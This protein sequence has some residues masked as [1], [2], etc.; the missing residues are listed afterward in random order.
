MVLGFVASLM[1]QT[2]SPPATD[3]MDISL[4]SG[5]HFI[6]QDV[7]AAS[8]KAFDDSG[9]SQVAA[10]HEWNNLDGQDGGGYYQGP[11]WY[12]RHY[13]LGNELSGQRLFLKFDGAN[14]ITD[15]WINGSYVGQHHGGFA[16][17]AF[18]VTTYLTTGAD[19]VIAVRVDNTYNANVPP[20]Q[21]DFTFHGGMYRKVHLL[22]LD[23]VHI[24]PLDLASPGIFLKTTGVSSNAA[25]LQIT[26]LV[27]NAT[28]IIKNLTI[29][30]LVTDAGTNIVVA[31]TNLVTLAPGALS[32]V[33]SSTTVIS[34]HL[35]NGLLD[36]YLHRVYVEVWEAGTLLDLVSQ[37]L[38]FRYFSFDSTNGFS[39][40]G[41]YYDLHGASMHQ[42]WLNRG[43]AIGD[44]ERITNIA[45]FKEIGATA[46][47]LSHYQHDEHTYQLADQNGFVLWTEAPIINLVTETPE[48]YTNS[49]QQL[50][51][52]IRQNFNH[53]SVFCWGLHNEENSSATNLIRQLQ[54]VAQQE[55]TT[56]P[57]TCA[58]SQGDGA[59]VNWI[60]DIMAF[61]KYYGWYSGTASDFGVW[62]DNI[63]ANYPTRCIGLSEY[64]AG[65]SV[66][67]HSEDPV[68]HPVTTSH[69]HPEEWQNLFHEAYWPQLKARRYL[70]CKFV[71]N[72]FDFA[73]E[74]R[75][76]GDTQG[77]NDKGL[78]TYDRQIRKDAFYWYK[79]NWTTNPMVYIT[80]HTFTNRLTNFVTSKVY[81]NCDSVELF[82]NGVSQ[83][84]KASTNCIFNWPVALVGG[85]NY[86]QAVGTKGASNVSD[87]LAWLAP[88]NS[89]FMVRITN[90]LTN[91]IYLNSTNDTLQVSAAVSNFTGSYSA[92]W[93]LVNSTGTAA[94][95]NSNA[96][97]TSVHFDATGLYLLGVTAS[98]PGAS[99][100]AGLTVVVGTNSF[101]TNG[102]IAWWKMDQTIGTI[103]ADSSGNARNVTLIGTSFVTGYL[104]NALQLAGSSGSYGSYY[105]AD[106][107][108]QS[109]AVWVKATGNGGGSYPYIL[110]SPSYRLLGRFTGTDANSVGF[111]TWDQTNG[112][113]DSGAGTIT[114][115]TWYHVVVTYDRNNRSTPP[116]FYLNG[117]KMATSILANPSG[118]TATLAGTGYIGNRSDG[119]RGWNGLIDDLRIYNRILN[120]TEVQLLAAMPPPNF[121]PVVT[122]GDNQ[123][124]V[125]SGLA[126]LSGTLS[127]DGKPSPPG[128]TTAGWSQLNGPGVVSFGNSH[129]PTTSASFSQPGVYLLQLMASDG[130]VQTVSTVTINFV[131]P[132]LSGQFISHSNLVSLSWPNQVG[133]HL[134][135]QTNK[136]DVGL[137]TN[138][139]DLPGTSNTNSI[140]L[141]MNRSNIGIFYRLT[142]P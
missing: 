122:A 73:A 12:R 27:S 112:D 95:G 110:T 99:N 9:W 94:F 71:W 55:D 125:W 63:H 91:V 47:R 118:T 39:L 81:A 60:S 72:M 109:L 28:A 113:Y 87:S 105:A 40:N 22:A 102:L 128:V 103:A 138:W 111:A 56:R 62:A 69:Y 34:P 117:K 2:Y 132:V 15:V 85:S 68:A 79:A 37:P 21:A 80:G 57:S 101:V 75:N 74:W 131:L 83:G 107:N 129:A 33:L 124:N 133:W 36:P 42:D 142:S 96:L 61:N 3:R 20:L 84:S 13:T 139:I 52:L 98:T 88:W 137:S 92:V 49:C 106:G 64:G 141:P 108:Q 4:D 48:F 38:G 58:S 104:S 53:P 5:W 29:R 23:P 136:P 50:R 97:A 120:D 19:N 90:P 25:T 32:N 135:C 45:L 70:W 134:Q 17:F 77:R 93:N 43:W 44:A 67:Q 100:S 1:A 116:V 30:A 11:G 6:R 86:L 78:V 54:A 121:A 65:A 26:A 114:Q 89:Q 16:A 66:W 46:I 10:P 123:T 8:N 41:N 115:N 82:V 18:D 51:E 24:T 119:A 14:I 127:D 76:E 7:P 130:Q 31:L 35:W 126:N 59:M 140:V